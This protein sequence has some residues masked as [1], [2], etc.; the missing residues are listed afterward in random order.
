MTFAISNT[1][2]AIVHLKTKHHIGPDGELPIGPYLHQQTI[3]A[4]FG[5]NTPKIIFNGDV[6]THLILRW[7][8]KMMH[9]VVQ[10]GGA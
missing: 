1:K 10:S 8:V 6:F 4:A 7:L 3:E 9:R 5:Q 2:N